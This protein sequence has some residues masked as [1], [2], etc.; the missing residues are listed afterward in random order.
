MLRV[1]EARE[2]TW[3][4]ACAR[5]FAPTPEVMRGVAEIVA[6]VRVRGDDALVAWTR[7]F[8][9]PRFD[10]AKMRVPIPMHDQ[11]RGLVSDDVARALREMRARMKRLAGT[12]SSAIDVGDDG[13]EAALLFE[14]YESIAVYVPGGAHPHPSALLAAIVP[15]RAAGVSRTVVMTPPA[16][17]GTVHP[18]MLH[19]CSLCEVDEL[20]AVGGAQAIA[21]AALGT[22]AVTPVRKIVGGR[23]P[24]VLEAKRLLNGNCEV[25]P[26]A[27][28]PS[29]LLLADEEASSECI[30]ADVLALAERGPDACVLVLSESR[31]LLEAIA[32]LLDTFGAAR[33]ERVCFLVRV[34]GRREALAIA[35]AAAPDCAVLHLRDAHAYAEHLRGV[36]TLLFG[37]GE[38]AL[39]G[40]AFVLPGAY[41]AADFVRPRIAS[42]QP[43]ERALVD[44]RATAA[45]AELEGLSAH[46]QSLR[47]RGEIA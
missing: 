47:L 19:A 41:V 38:C 17:D 9:D 43:A 18:S 33:L 44:S 36:R 31:P 39:A 23:S 15:A 1:A 2:R 7:R 8:D 22:G 30:A 20:Y 37:S 4:A 25:D 13:S 12:L 42:R 34:A 14:P 21:A 6:D 26:I 27:A 16:A 5:A 45:L 28:P 29:A 3:A 35:A 24:W 46:A 32:Q 40:G 11:A 10:L